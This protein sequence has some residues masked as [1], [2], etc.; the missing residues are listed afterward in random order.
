MIWEVIEDGNGDYIQLSTWL[1]AQENGVQE[2]AEP[3][4]ALCAYSGTSLLAVSL[5]TR[6]LKTDIFP[7]DTIFFYMSSSLKALFSTMKTAKACSDFHGQYA[8]SR[9][10]PRLAS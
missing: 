8:E 9:Q 4:P 3:P 6:N 2:L 7:K 10:T 5:P 1:Q